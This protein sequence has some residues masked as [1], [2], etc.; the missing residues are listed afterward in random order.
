MSS[1]SEFCY[2]SALKKPC[3]INIIQE[4]KRSK[5][6]ASTLKVSNFMAVI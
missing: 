4:T 6:I 2:N 1:I 5:V 3:E